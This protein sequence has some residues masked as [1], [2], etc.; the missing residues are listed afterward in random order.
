VSIQETITSDDCFSYQLSRFRIRDPLLRIRIAKPSGFGTDK[1]MRI[2]A[3]PDPQNF[4][5]TSSALRRTRYWIFTWDGSS[6]LK[7]IL[8]DFV[9]KRRP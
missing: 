5:Q 7:N 6:S 8:E 4:G 1:K 9:T 3:D 2:H